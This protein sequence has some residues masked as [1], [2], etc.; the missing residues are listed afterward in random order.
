[1]TYSSP[2]S[3]RY[4]S[5]AMQALW[6]ERRRIGLWRRL[7]LALMEVERELGLDIPERAL[8]ELRAHLDDAD[9]ERAAEYEKRL[10][11]DVMAHIHHLGEQAPAARAFLHLG[12]T[13]A[14][15]TDNTDLI[16]MREGLQLLLGRIAA[17][18][19]ALAK[20]ARRERAV[21]CLAY[22]HFQPAQLTT[23]GKRVTLWMQE[24]LLDAEELLHRLDTLQFRGV[25]GTTGTQASFLELF[26]GDDE[27][28]RELDARVALKMGF[29]K[30]F[31]VTGQTY[32]RKVDAQVLAALSGVAQSAAKLATDLRLL[33]HEGEMLEPFESDQVGSSAMAYKRNPM[34]AER[35]T[36]L[37]RFVIE[38]EGNAWHTASEQW[39]E[40]TLDDSANRRL[41]LPEAFLASDAILVL[42]TNVAAGL[43]VREAVIARHVAA[44]LPFLATERLLMRGV[45]AGGDRQ[46]LHEVIRTH[47]LAV[48]QA[49]AEQG[50]ANDLL[51]R[52]ARDPAFKA[53]HVALAADELDPAA[54]VGR[55][56]RQVDEFLER[57]LP[58]VL[59]RI[60]AV[61][62]AV[63]TAEV[64]V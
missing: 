49:M 61:A 19:V 15:V 38:L 32:T 16:L 52:L 10:R 58:G 50:A 22:T 7:W 43:E 6:G 26:D 2:L 4:A 37:A 35:I 57:V 18:L 34:R 31:P 28:V 48:A 53:L 62:P 39:L 29:A 25:K 41:V 33:Q 36:G 47:S 42:A 60:E 8:V 24:S 54:Y 45:K 63:A 51:D 46:R 44:Q 14:Y 9:L 3:Q 13:S 55:A 12:A 23:V 5:P 1:M 40:R 59:H 11:H 56:P 20:L 30:V 21:P 17:V 64:N 27:K